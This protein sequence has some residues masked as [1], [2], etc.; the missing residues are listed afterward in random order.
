MW[1]GRHSRPKF[2]PLNFNTLF[3]RASQKEN[4][5]ENVNSYNSPKLFVGRDSE[6]TSSNKMIEDNDHEEDVS[7]LFE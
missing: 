6:E 2:L 3:V 5:I 7:M 4:I 1:G